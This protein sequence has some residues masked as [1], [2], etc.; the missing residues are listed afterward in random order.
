MS[1]QFTARPTPSR[2]TRVA[3]VL[4][5]LSTILGGLVDGIVGAGATPPPS[6]DHVPGQIVV[7]FDASADHAERGRVRASVR[8][9]EHAEVA[10]LDLHVW[11]VPA[12]AVD[13]VLRAL[14]QHPSVQYAE[15]DSTV[16]L[17]GEVVPNDPKWPNQGQLQR[18]EAPSAWG[19]TT[20]SSSVQVAVLDTGVNAVS[21]LDENL[22][23]GHNVLD[24]STDVTDMNGHGTL[25]AGVVGAETNNGEAIAS[26]GFD[27]SILPVK[28]LDGSSGS[29]S[30]LVR[31]IVWAADNGADVISMSLSGS[32]GMSSLQDAVQ[33][34]AARDV[35]LVAAAGN[36]GDSVKRYPAAYPEV[37]GVAGTDPYDEL[38]TWSNYGDWV[39]VSAP[40]INL[41]VYMDGSVSTFAG[42]SSAT[43][44]VAGLAGLG[45]SLGASAV[46]IRDAIQQGSVPLGFVQ[47][48]RVDA[49]ATVSSLAGGS[50]GETE[51]NTTPTAAIDAA[52]LE[53]ACDL[54]GSASSDSDGSVASYAWDL[55]DGAS[56]VEPTVSHQYQ[57]S[58]TYTVTLTV[59]DDDGATSMTSTQVDVEESSD[60]SDSS[61]TDTSVTAVAG[62]TND[63]GSWTAWVDVTVVVDG[64]SASGT[65]VTGDWTG[66]GKHGRSGTATCTTDVSGVC[67]LSVS[68]ENRV[69]AVDWRIQTAAGETTARSVKP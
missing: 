1:I 23:V 4:F 41:S 37:I 65:T 48:G 44:V 2:W 56:A 25:A 24:G 55:G 40:G 22:L 16:E 62:S 51:S 31:G 19:V 49:Y 29:M 50:G 6:D 36:N 39:D 26:I 60:D 43:P 14:D 38:Y 53:L 68:Q 28:V 27:T 5:V 33:Y 57:A 12:H 3:A 11:R 8:A 54:D 61:T 58:G 47:Y 17:D 52:C 21:E 45:T 15:V 7:R 18:I 20:G 9:A 64:A 69:S 34:A 46:E 32:S 63:K 10:A 59:T 66:E 42:T 35:V 67:R 30:D 13:R